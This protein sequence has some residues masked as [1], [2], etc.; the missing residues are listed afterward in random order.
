MLTTCSESVILTGVSTTMVALFVARFLDLQVACF[1]GASS[2]V[3]TI[4]VGHASNHTHNRQMDERDPNIN[5][6]S[7]NVASLNR[8][9]TESSLERRSVNVASII[10]RRCHYVGH[11]N[12]IEKGRRLY[13]S[14]NFEDHHRLQMQFIRSL[15]SQTNQLYEKEYEKEKV[16][17]DNP[18]EMNE[19]H[20]THDTH[21]TQ[22]IQG[23][24]GVQCIQGVQGVQCIQG[25]QGV[26]GVQG[27]QD[28]QE[29]RNTQDASREKEQMMPQSAPPPTFHLNQNPMPL[30]PVNWS[31]GAF[32][33]V[34]QKRS[35]ILSAPE[36]YAEIVH[37]GHEKTKYP[38]YKVILLSIVA[39]CYVG[40]AFTTALLVG[41]SM[42]EA[43]PLLRDTCAWA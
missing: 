19:L 10:R 29:G 23:V 40:F 27:M 38:T 35:Y 36:I 3:P 33:A 25:V 21:N 13:Q 1:G 41:G 17:R 11:S 2:V 9:P 24:Q 43:P 26:Q 32:E 12:E 14:G 7:V 37:H 42:N 8:N 18:N 4:N 6:K 30:W 34:S 5:A 20:D 15:T 16:D 39:G 31:S 22:G 28:M